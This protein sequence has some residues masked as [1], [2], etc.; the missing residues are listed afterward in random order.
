MLTLL[1]A[2]LFNNEPIEVFVT[3]PTGFSSFQSITIIQEK[4]HGRS[5]KNW[6]FDVTELCLMPH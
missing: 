2:A 5:A 4:Y 1:L 6:D 3:F